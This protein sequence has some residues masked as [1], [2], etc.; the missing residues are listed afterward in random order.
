MD[1]EAIHCCRTFDAWRLK[2]GES[3]DETFR[4]VLLQ[5]EAQ[6]KKALFASTTTTM[7]VVP[8]ERLEV[9]LSVAKLPIYTK[10]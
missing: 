3:F 4:A 9:R 1:R 8:I 7:P 2:D 10:E 5:L 6:C